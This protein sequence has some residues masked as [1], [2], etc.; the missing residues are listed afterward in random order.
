MIRCSGGRSAK[1]T[2]PPGWGG[3]AH[4]S[5]LAACARQVQV[6]QTAGPQRARE[7]RDGRRRY[8][9]DGGSQAIRESGDGE[10]SR[11]VNQE[12]EVNPTHEPGW[13]G[14]PAFPPPLLLTR[15]DA[16]RWLSPSVT[17]PAQQCLV[18]VLVSVAKYLLGGV[19]KAASCRPQV[20]GQR[21]FVASPQS[22]T[23]RC[24]QGATWSVLTALSVLGRWGQDAA[25]DRPND[26]EAAAPTLHT[27][28]KERN[29]H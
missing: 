12:G 6:L 4:A 3:F 26:L 17:G 29:D 18:D 28:R 5:S 14:P 9:N 27:R 22:S 24:A 25:P 1:S 7:T 2:K 8:A 15:P 21:R 13:P 11:S 10:S 16:W 23:G 19:G 20:V